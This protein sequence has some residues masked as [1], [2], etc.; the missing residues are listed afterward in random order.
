MYIFSYTVGNLVNLAHFYANV[1]NF[2]KSQGFAM[3][4]GSLT[5]SI[6]HDQR[7]SFFSV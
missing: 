3:F 7:F 4:S 2:C 1:N 5:L 6:N